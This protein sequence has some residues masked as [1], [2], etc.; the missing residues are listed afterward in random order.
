MAYFQKE[1]LDA[2]SGLY[3]HLIDEVCNKGHISLDRKGKIIQEYAETC[4]PGAVGLNLLD[5]L[6]DMAAKGLVKEYA[7]ASDLKQECERCGL[8]SKD[9]KWV[10]TAMG[11]KAK[12]IVSEDI[13]LFE[14]KAKAWTAAKK[15]QIKAN[16]KGSI[17]KL[18]KKN[19][20]AVR[21]G[22]GAIEQLLEW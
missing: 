19:G 3:C 9:Y 5:W 4:S 1:R 21:C 14:P 15:K 7:E 22:A 12:L 2:S 8:P 6:A 17:A 11:A 20:I 18:L 16:S 10:G 13:D